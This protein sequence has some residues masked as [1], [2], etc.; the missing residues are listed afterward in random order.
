MQKEVDSA[1]WLHGMHGTGA[2]NDLIV[3][4]KSEIDVELC[5]PQRPRAELMLGSL[6][7]LSLA[8]HHLSMVRVSSLKHY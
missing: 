6:C 8:I 1:N 2:K 3:A 5:H 7:H 4:Q